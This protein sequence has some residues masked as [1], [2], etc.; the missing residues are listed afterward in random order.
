MLTVVDRRVTFQ[1]FRRWQRFV[2]QYLRRSQNYKL[3]IRKYVFYNYENTHFVQH[4][5]LRAT[6]SEGKLIS[7]PTFRKSRG[8]IV[9]FFIFHSC[10]ELFYKCHLRTNPEENG[11]NRIGSHLVSH[12]HCSHLVGSHLVSHDNA[13]LRLYNFYAEGIARVWVALWLFAQVGQAED[14]YGTPT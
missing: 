4:N 11:S 14:F 7:P 13:P 6:R 2:A 10:L 1:I 8:M 3:H 5:K 12:M 9:P